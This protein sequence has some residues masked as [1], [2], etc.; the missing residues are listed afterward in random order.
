MGEYLW[1]RRVA[2]GAVR[3]RVGAGDGAQA[4]G[5]RC[6]RLG[7]AAKAPG[8]CDTSGGL[9]PCR[10]LTGAILA[11]PRGDFG[12]AGA[13]RG[14][15]A[16]IVARTWPS[17][18]LAS[19]FSEKGVRLWGGSSSNGLKRP[20]GYATEGRRVRGGFELGSYELRSELEAE[21]GSYE[22]RSEIGPCELK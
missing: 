21:L 9:R 16:A 1:E 4:E 22:L 13:S 7:S 8:P 20:G 19:A 6:G 2:G 18:Q 14:R 17:F 11:V 10:C 12:P 15:T 5:M 3:G